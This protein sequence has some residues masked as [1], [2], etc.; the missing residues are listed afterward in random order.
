MVQLAADLASFNNTS[1]EE[2]L[3]SLQSGISGETEPLKK[4]GIVLSDVR[5]KEEALRLGLIKTTKDALTPA[6]KAGTGK[7]A[8]RK[9]AGR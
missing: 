8:A 5:L 9:A 6:A 7:P 4:Y 3:T 2:A 1:I